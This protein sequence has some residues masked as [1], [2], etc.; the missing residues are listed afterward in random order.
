MPSTFRVSFK[1]PKELVQETGLRPPDVPFGHFTSMLAD[2]L[3]PRLSC[4]VVQMPPSFARTP[5][6]EL[7]LRVFV[8]QWSAQ[9]PLAIEFRHRTWRVAEVDDLLRAHNV[10]TIS[11][12]LRDVPG[13]TP[14]RCEYKS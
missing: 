12:D 5:D 6:N 1:A 10:A 8:T 4:I 3:G 2:R 14:P 11:H 9:V 7:A 13:L